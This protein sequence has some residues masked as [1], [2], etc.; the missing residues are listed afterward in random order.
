MENVIGDIMDNIVTKKEELTTKDYKLIQEFNN[1]CTKLQ[2]K[3]SFEECFICL[4]KK[5]GFSYA[6]LKKLLI[7]IKDIYNIK[8]EKQKDHN[9]KEQI[10]PYNN[11]LFIENCLREYNNFRMMMLDIININISGIKT[12]IKENA[13]TYIKKILSLYEDKGI[14]SVLEEIINKDGIQITTLSKEYFDNIVYYAL[15]YEKLNLKHNDYYLSDIFILAKII[16]GYDLLINKV[17][18]HNPHASYFNGDVDYILS[19][20]NKARSINGITP[21]ELME[22]LAKQNLD[23]VQVEKNMSFY[24]NYLSNENNKRKEQQRI[25]YMNNLDNE[26]DEC[27]KII[28]R[29]LDSKYLLLEDYLKNNR[30]SKEKFDKALSVLKAKE[31]PIYSLYV[32]K[33][34]ESLAQVDFASLIE[35][36]E[37]GILKN[38]RKVRDFDLIDYYTLTKVSLNEAKRLAKKLLPYNQYIIISNFIKKYNNDYMI[39]ESNINAILKI[40]I[41]YP[42][43]GSIYKV[44]DDDKRST[45]LKLGEMKIPMTIYTYKI[46]LR[47][48]VMNKIYQGNN[49]KKFIK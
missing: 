24:A 8:I 17:S 44:S 27:V 16:I 25:E 23:E 4:H 48:Y 10:I 5:I 49:P 11:I 15:V 37:K 6:R 40:E 43:E 21:L 22:I 3:S 46:L 32:K 14:L 26:I 38:G 42:L 13:D 39:T 2:E 29:Y 19:L 47:R 9:L 34:Q 20:A 36:I 30:I 1:I 35:G 41:S 45:I 31:H 28:E 12:T 7:S 33:E 18:L